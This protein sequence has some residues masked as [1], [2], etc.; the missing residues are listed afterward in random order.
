MTRF[1]VL[2]ALL[3]GACGSC[4]TDA[5]RGDTDGG[6]NNGANNGGATNNGDNNGTTGSNNGADP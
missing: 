6:A 2:T 5:I 4:R 1:V 3:L